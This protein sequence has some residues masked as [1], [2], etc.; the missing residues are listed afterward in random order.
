MKLHP[1][2]QILLA[3][4]S[5]LYGVGVTVHDL[6]Y[7]MDI[8]RGSKFNVPTIVVG[9]LTMGGSGK[10]P[11][12]EYIA[13]FLRVYV[14]TGILSR[15]YKRKTHGYLR[16][17][18][19]TTV[20]DGGDEPMQYVRKFPNVFVA[21]GENR[22][23]AIITMKGQAPHLQCI[24]LDDAFQ[25]R[26]VEAGLNI[27]LTEFSLPFTRDYLLPSGRLREW[28]AGY[29]R[30]DIIIVT[31]CPP[32]ISPEQRTKLLAEI[33]PYAH[34]KVFFSKY[35]YGAPYRF[36]Y[37]SLTTHLTTG[38]D[39]LLICAIARA[40]YLMAYLKTKVNSIKTIEYGDHHFFE[41]TDIG[42]LKR[43]Y[44][45]ISAR[46][47]IIITTEKDAMRLEEHW[48]LIRE[49]DLPIFVLPVKVGFMDADEEDFQD[50]VADYLLGVK[51]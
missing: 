51:K 5:L 6:L 48:D 10:T 18:E 4:A 13:D 29:K 12:V 31:K 42:N 38:T 45:G 27:L 7:R 1:L 26:A 15:G 35:I 34:Q 3:P 8:L 30:A 17:T 33:K 49:Y 50:S 46:N 24:I 43:E 21:V 14:S 36:M 47:K 28:R 37:P 41:R 40:D 39:V 2:L 9:N 44:N 19:N 22:T 11:H 32:Q 20:A 25:H 16:L 23:N